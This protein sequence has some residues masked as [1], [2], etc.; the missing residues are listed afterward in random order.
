[1]MRTHVKWLVGLILVVIVSLLAISIT[2]ICG[3]KGDMFDEYILDATTFQ[4]RI[5]AFSESGLSLFTSGAI[6]TIESKTSG[7][8]EWTKITSFRHDDERPIPCQQ[9]VLLDTGICYFY[10]AWIYGV[11]TDSG[12]TWSIWNAELDL[13][14]YHGKNY[15]LIKNVEIL[16]DGNGVMGLSI[17]GFRARKLYSN[18]FGKSWQI[19]RESD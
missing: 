2:P 1:M 5:R 9:F 6:Y 4:L 3:L 15:Q 7:T 16:P 18:D 12:L 17:V 13:Q 10:F 14:G 8:A 11:T 19:Q